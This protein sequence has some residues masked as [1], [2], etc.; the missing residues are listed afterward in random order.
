M[1]PRVLVVEDDA[2][3]SELVAALVEQ[4]GC[5]VLTA[6]TG[7]AG[8]RLAERERPDLILMDVQLP[9]LTGYEVTRRLKANPATTGSPSWP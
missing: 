7:D 8:L 4:S 9:G 2:L 1:A 3:N 6:G 5:E